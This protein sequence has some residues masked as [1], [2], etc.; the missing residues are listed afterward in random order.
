MEDALLK[1]PCIC[2]H[3][4]LVTS[5]CTPVTSHYTCDTHCTLVTSHHILVTSHHILVTSHHILVT[6]H[7][8]LVTSHHTTYLWHH[9]TY[10][11]H[12]TTPHTCDITPHTCDITPHHIL[13]TSHHILVTSH[14]TLQASLSCTFLPHFAITGYAMEGMLL[15]SIPASIHTGE[16]RKKNRWASSLTHQ[17]KGEYFCVATGSHLLSQQVWQPVEW[18]LQHSVTIMIILSKN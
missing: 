5:P 18:E 15:D 8:I 1:Y 16:R 2:L 4:T 14:C 6:S 12:H 3:R 13:V 9:T 10:L 17:C 11:W 7:H